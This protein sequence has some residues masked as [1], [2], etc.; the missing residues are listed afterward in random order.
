MRLYR[1]YVIAQDALEVLQVYRLVYS[2]VVAYL[3]AACHQ[4]EAVLT[5]IGLS[6]HCVF[7]RKFLVQGNNTVLKIVLSQ[8]SNGHINLEPLHTH[9]ETSKSPPLV[10]FGHFLFADSPDIVVSH[11]ISHKMEGRRGCETIQELRH[12]ARCAGSPASVSS[13]V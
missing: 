7:P 8:T 9:K 10:R 12:C 6:H 1:N 11:V 4:L 5:G 13:G 3:Y 2:P